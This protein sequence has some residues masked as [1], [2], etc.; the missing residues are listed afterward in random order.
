MTTGQ[1]PLLHEMKQVIGAQATAVADDITIGRLPFAATLIEAFYIAEADITGVNTNTRRHAIV[2]K[3][4]DGNGNVEMASLQYNA[5]VNTTDFDEKDLTLSG[6]P[7]NL[8]GAEGDI[9]AFRSGVVG[10]GLAD[11]GGT[12][13]CVFSRN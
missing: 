7:A 2:N 4:L 10:T 8:V 6:V 12:V 5:G 11:P 1:A 3:L 13:V 9:I